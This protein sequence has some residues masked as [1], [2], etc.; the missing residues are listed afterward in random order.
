M[1]FSRGIALEQA[2]ARAEAADVPRRVIDR[3]LADGVAEQLADRL[4]DGPEL[5]RVVAGALESSG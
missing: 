2:L 4:L 3:L 5:E 1:S